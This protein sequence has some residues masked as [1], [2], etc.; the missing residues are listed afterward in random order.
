MSQESGS[1]I[2]EPKQILTKEGNT[3]M[4][5]NS[6]H[7]II[8]KDDG[9][10]SP[11]EIGQS[12]DAIVKNLLNA[13]ISIE[14]LNESN[15]LA[16]KNETSA[17]LDQALIKVNQELLLLLVMLFFTVLLFGLL[18]TLFLLYFLYL[19]KCLIKK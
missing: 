17:A 1:S 3:E 14:I 7:H 5:N 12:S 9:F 6:E 13:E 15:L 2:K 16:A 19:Q 11:K 10:L 18:L 8:N 4:A